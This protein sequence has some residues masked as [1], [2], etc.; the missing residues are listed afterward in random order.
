MTEEG[1]ALFLELSNPVATRVKCPR[2]G[3][4]DILAV[5]VLGVNHDTAKFLCPLCEKEG[6]SDLVT[7]L[8]PTQPKEE[9]HEEATREEGPQG[10]VQ[11]PPA[12][13]LSGPE[14]YS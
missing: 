5:K 13:D 14:A 2:C 10:P 7:G 9:K 8:S 3:W 11:I 12:S 6:T 4:V 1:M